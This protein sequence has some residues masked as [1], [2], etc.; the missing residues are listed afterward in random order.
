MNEKTPKTKPERG[1]TPQPDHIMLSFCGDAKT[2]MAVTWRTSTDVETGYMLFTPAAGGEEVRVDAINRR[3]ESDIDESFMHWAI[4]ENLTPGTGYTYT[5]GDDTH[6]SARFSFETE[7]E[8]LE[9]FKFVLV[10]DQQKGNPWER[11]DYAVFNKLLKEVFEKHPDCKF[12]FT[13]GDNCD[14]GMNEIQWNAMFE[15]LQGIAESKPYMM[16]TGNHDNRGFM[17]YFGQTGKFYARKAFFFDE[18][19]AYSY[20]RNGP[21]GLETENYSFDYGHAHFTVVGINEQPVLADWVY[22]DLQK[23]DKTWKLGAYHFPIYPVM[24][25]GD[26]DDS[27]PY[28]RKGFEEGRLDVLFA[29]HEHSFARTYPMKNDEMF[30]RPSEGTVHYIAGNA[31]RNIYTTNCR[32]IWHPYYYPQEEPLYLYAIVDVFPSL[33]IITAYLEDGR[34]VDQFTID[35][36]KDLIYPYELAPIFKE[37]KMSFKGQIPELAARGVYCRKHNDLWYCPFGALVAF[38]GGTVEKR[39]GELFVSVYKKYA[40]FIEN[41]RIAHTHA[42]DF[43]MSGEVWRERDQL[44]VPVADAA[45]IFGMD[46]QFAERNNLINFDYPSE[47]RTYTP[48][49]QLAAE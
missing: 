48:H 47:E 9:H 41:S 4:A 26:D 16:C 14:D 43:E 10:T 40:S 37:T 23:N 33:L 32:K 6:R 30:D 3:F 2:T 20:P 12:I 31:G 36:S 5:V 45:E 22:E 7:P 21:E 17:D 24:P 46:W 42:G 28:L 39:P 1:S 27:Y 15:G 19:F 44:Y 18:Q 38:I 25:E 11:P 8:N 35:K 49:P 13:A 29:G 34:I